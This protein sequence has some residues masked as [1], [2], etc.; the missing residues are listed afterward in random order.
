LPYNI[1]TAVVARLLAEGRRFSRLVLM[2]QREVA[3][4][5]RAHPGTKDYSALTV[6]TQCAARVRT[7]LRV[8]PHAFVPPPKVD[9]EVVILEP[10]VGPPV[11]V[12]DPAVFRRG[13]RAAFNQRRKQLIN[14]LRS[15]CADAPA[16]LRAAGIDPTRRAETLT[17]EEFATLANIIGREGP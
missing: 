12:D 17:L 4:R 11:K 7:G 6:L 15:V 9:S 13:V 2:L 5:L 10:H 14:S 8:P 3:E 1:A 16:S